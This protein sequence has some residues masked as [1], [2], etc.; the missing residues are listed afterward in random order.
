MKNLHP[1]VVK[2]AVHAAQSTVMAIEKSNFLAARYTGR[3]LELNH[4]VTYELTEQGLREMKVIIPPI[5]AVQN[6]VEQMMQNPAI[7]SMVR[8]TVGQI[9]KTLGIPERN[10]REA[11]K[12]IRT[13][14]LNFID[15]LNI[16]LQAQLPDTSVNV[17]DANG[18]ILKPKR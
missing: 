6:V 1:E 17:I 7:D 13:E 8:S 16:N 3:T 11:L 2:K 9:P 10:R 12:D 18:N 5:T 14:K 15:L 4:E